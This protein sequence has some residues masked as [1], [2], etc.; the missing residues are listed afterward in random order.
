MIKNI[1]FDVG[2]VLVDFRPD[3]VMRDLKL[4]E[5][6]IN[7]LLNA[8]CFNPLWSEFDRGVI[9]DDIVIEMMKKESP[10]LADYIDK[11][12]EK[13]WYNLVESYSYSANW[14]HGL[15]NRG[16]KTY[17][18]SNYPAAAFLLHSKKDF[19]FIPYIDGKIVSGF[20]K[21]IKPD[22]AIYEKLLSEYKLNASECVFIDDRLENVQAA[23]D[24][25]FSGI[26]F[27]NYNQANSELESLLQIEK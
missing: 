2:N 4:P 3:K 5:E 13:R 23:V 12:F 14:L 7:A 9:D 6:K 8:T 17:L 26:H 21:L 1:V 19:S 20:V 11:F 27:K 18:L 15:Q 24:L 25:G 10:E 22:F 16:Y